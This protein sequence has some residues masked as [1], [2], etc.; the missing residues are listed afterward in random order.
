MIRY[1][2][3]V[4]FTKLWSAES[5]VSEDDKRNNPINKKKS[6]NIK[7]DLQNIEAGEG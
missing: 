7:F 5:L 3:Q 1:K 6:T 4:R 2:T